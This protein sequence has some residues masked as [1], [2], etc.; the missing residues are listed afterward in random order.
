MVKFTGAPFLSPC[1]AFKTAL[2]LKAAWIPIKQQ[3]GKCQPV[4]KAEY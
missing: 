2:L 3:V 4:E 1:G